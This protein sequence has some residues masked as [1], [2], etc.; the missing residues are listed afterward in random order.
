M[1]IIQKNK[2]RIKNLLINI[3]INLKINYVKAENPYQILG[4][5]IGQSIP[6]D[7]DLSYVNS[8]TITGFKSS[9]ITNDT[10]LI[11]MT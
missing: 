10:K 8:L 7:T 2:N 6:E 4:T 5:V 3:G 9:I 1:I 11:N